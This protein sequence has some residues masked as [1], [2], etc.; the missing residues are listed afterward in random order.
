M[1]KLSIVLTAAAGMLAAPAMAADLRMPVKAPPA[2][3]L[4]A[5]NWS[6]FYIGGFVGGAFSGARDGTDVA[7]VETGPFV[8]NSLTPFGYDLDTSIIGGGTIGWNFQAPGS[9]FVFGI[10][11]EGGYMNLRRSVADPLSPA[12]DTVSTT[13]IGDFYAMITGRLGLAWDRTLIYVK[14]GGA[15]V[16]RSVRVLDTCNIAPCGPATVTARGNLDEFT[17]TAGG[18]IEFALGSNWSVK[19]EYMYIDT[20]DTIT[21][22]GNAAPGGAA[23]SW[24]HAL[25]GVHTAKFGINYRFGW[26]GP[27]AARY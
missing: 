11:G 2:A 18:G 26:G 17:W 25:P 1:K 9:P 5:Y 24:A 23:V 14:G 6:G 3:V 16:D 12:L 8:Y 13:T 27:I 20:R 4:S 22:T 7:V 21:A 19:G 10:E 15:Y